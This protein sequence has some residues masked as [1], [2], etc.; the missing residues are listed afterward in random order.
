MLSRS[1]KTNLPRPYSNC[2][3]DNQTNA[4]FHSELFDLIQNSEYR[5]KQELCFWQCVQRAILQE[6]NCTC[7]AFMSLFSNAS[8]CIEKSQIECMNSLTATKKTFSQSD[9]Y[10]VNCE[11]ECPLECYSDSFDYSLSASELISKNYLDY[12]NSNST[13]LSRDF[14][15]MT[16]DTET[17]RRSFVWA[18]VFYK[19]LSYE[20][21]TES[22]QL[23]AI[24]L[25]A[26]IGGYLGLFLGVSVFSLFEPVQILIEIIYLK[27]HK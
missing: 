25:I 7:P 27:Y 20:L 26:N 11:S 4:G 13:N 5:Y 14:E 12:L 19:S 17:A 18:N 9:F 21:S 23:I 24:T 6:C 16:L 10:Q 1:F 2:L 15:N 22:P 3:V 8:Q